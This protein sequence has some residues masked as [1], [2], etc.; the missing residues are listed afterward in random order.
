M[1]SMFDFDV[2][3]DFGK[4]RYQQMIRDAN[5]GRCLTRIQS[6]TSKHHELWLKKVDQQ[7]RSLRVQLT[8]LAKA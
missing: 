6:V 2:N 4:E 8:R 1:N 3:H 7:V 5:I